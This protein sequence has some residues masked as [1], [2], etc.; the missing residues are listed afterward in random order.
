[1]A[2]DTRDRLVQAAVAVLAEAGIAGLSAR[3]VGARAGANPALIYYHFDDLDGLLVESSRTVTAARADAYAAR[4]ATVED[5]RG[6][7]SAA[8][9]LHAEEQ[10]NGNLAMLTQ[11]FAG[12]RT[13]PALAPV[14]SENF[15]LLAAQVSGAL[16][17]ILVDTPLAGLVDTRQLARTVSA[18]F[19]GVELLD[20]VTGDDVGLFDTLDTLADLVDV[21]LSAGTIPSA[22]IRRRLDP[23]RRG[24]G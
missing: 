13:R 22:L 21:V 19:I 7:A 11:L 16:D 20:T 3:A 8:R 1:M 15:E 2:D 18:G 9:E 17:R 14:L 24:T 6:L 5:L 10:A 23:G 4:L 12:A